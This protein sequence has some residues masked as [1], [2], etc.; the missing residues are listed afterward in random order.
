MMTMMVFP[1]GLS[2]MMAGVILANSTMTMMDWTI[3]WMMTTMETVSLILTKTAAF[4][5]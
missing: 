5:D 4:S 1:T 2:R 3:I